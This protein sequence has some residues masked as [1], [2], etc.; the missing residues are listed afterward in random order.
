MLHFDWTISVYYFWTAY[1]WSMHIF[2]PTWSSFLHVLICIPQWWLATYTIVLDSQE[3][4]CLPF[5]VLQ[6]MSNFIDVGHQSS[7]FTTW[8]KNHEIYCPIFKKKIIITSCNVGHLSWYKNE[9]CTGHFQLIK[10]L[11]FSLLSC[12]VD[13]L[14]RVVCPIRSVVN[15]RRYYIPNQKLLFPNGGHIGWKELFWRTCV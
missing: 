3:N 7:N 1:A 10:S 5:S 6:S 9:P 11:Y 12:H 8:K 2:G 4:D 13:D 15:P 14:R